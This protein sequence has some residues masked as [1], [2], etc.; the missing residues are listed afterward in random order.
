MKFLG[1]RKHRFGSLTEVV[2]SWLQEPIVSNRPVEDFYVGTRPNTDDVVWWGGEWYPVT[3]LGHLLTIGKTGAGKTLLGN[4]TLASVLE[5]VKTRGDRRVAI[6]D[7]KG[8]VLSLLEG[9]GVRYTLMNINDLRASAWDIAA[10]FQDYDKVVELAH[11]LLPQRGGGDNAFFQNAARDIV[12]GIMMSFIYRHGKFWGLHDVFNAALSDRDTVVEILRRYPRG[13]DLIEFYFNTEAEKTFDNIRMQIASELMP[14]ILP[15]AHS[16]WAGER[17]FSLTDFLGQEG[18]VLVIS[19]D[20]AAREASNPLIRAMFRRLIDLLSASREIDTKD[21]DETRRTFIFLDEARFLRKLPGLLDALTFTRSKGGIVSMNVQGKDGFVAEYGREAAEEIFNN[22][23]YISILHFRGEETARWCQSLYGT[24]ERHEENFST[25]Y[26]SSGM[27]VTSNL[28]RY[29]RPEYLDSDFL[30][31]P[32]PSREY[33]LEGFFISPDFTGD[34]RLHLPGEELEF[35]KPPTRRVPPQISKPG[36]QKLP[37]PWS[38]EERER[39]VY[40]RTVK[41]VVQF[42]GGFSSPKGMYSS[43]ASEVRRCMEEGLVG[44]VWE[45]VYELYCNLLASRNGGFKY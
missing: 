45:G 3:W 24:V 25:S 39:L 13:R 20:L 27:S 26:G 33:G 21:P 11:L 12:S 35:L 14:L 37:K 23:D 6:F 43:L 16:Q 8:D 9:L 7:S 17:K 18:E 41:R 42:Q 30:K 5:R 34:P 29:L 38:K 31:L 4:I 36:N 44:E 32:K 19:Q 28:Q 15:A 1:G 22:T 10:D 2:D 40:G